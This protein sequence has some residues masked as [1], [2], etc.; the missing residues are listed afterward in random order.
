MS[1]YEQMRESIYPFVKCSC[2]DCEIISC[3]K[4]DPYCAELT[5]NTD[6]LLS[7]ILIG[8]IPLKELSEKIGQ[9]GGKLAIVNPAEILAMKRPNIKEVYWQEE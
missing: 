4:L 5:E 8:G 2:Q 6:K 3:L 1:K 9:L 7:Q